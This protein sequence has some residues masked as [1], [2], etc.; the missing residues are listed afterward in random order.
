MLQERFETTKKVG[1]LGMFA[2]LFLLSIKAVIG[3][4]SGS[5]AMIADAFNSATDI[6]SSFMTYVGSKIS[7]VPSDN[8]HNYGHGKAEYIF[9]LLIGVIMI[10]LCINIFYQSLMSI[11][12]QETFVFSWWL[13]IVCIITIITKLALYF[14]V[15]KKGKDI[16]SLLVIANAQ[17]HINDVF[18]TFGT[19]IG[20]LGAL[21][22]MYWLDGTIGCLIS[23]WIFFVGTKISL[24]SCEILMDKSIDENMKKSII[25]K[26]KNYSEIDNIDKITSKPIGNNY[27]IIIE[28]SINGEMTVNHSHDIITKLQYDILTINHISD[29]IIHIN[30]SK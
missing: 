15:N 29:V 24:K 21:F 13:V 11:I 5:Y 18:L 16:D 30:P 2:N 19:L 23:I 20:V 6:I 9:S 1:I 4:I 26:V 10:I 22:N 25:Q 7:S 8:D 28:V 14:Y 12:H 3:F 17:D 27:I